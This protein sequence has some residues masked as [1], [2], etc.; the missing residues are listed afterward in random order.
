MWLCFKTFKIFSGNVGKRW[1]GYEFERSFLWKKISCKKKI[2]EIFPEKK[3]KLQTANVQTLILRKILQEFEFLR[4]RQKKQRRFSHDFFCLFWKSV[5][6]TLGL[7]NNELIQG[8]AFAH[9]S[10]FSES[11]NLEYFLFEISHSPEKFFN[12]FCINKWTQCIS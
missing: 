1:H 9:F 6:V 12:S 4:L 7:N 2:L 5:D 10:L 11:W 8:R 3:M